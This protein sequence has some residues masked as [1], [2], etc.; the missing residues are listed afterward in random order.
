MTLST[1]ERRALLAVHNGS[2]YGDT[3]AG[4]VRTTALQ[5]LEERGLVTHTGWFFKPWEYTKE[6]EAV[7]VVEGSCE[8]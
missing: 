7:V 1:E 8:R 5:S 3:I 2:A 4:R 6:G